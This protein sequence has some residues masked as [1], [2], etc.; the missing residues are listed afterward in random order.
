MIKDLS[1]IMKC[2]FP[3]DPSD[4]AVVGTHDRG[5]KCTQQ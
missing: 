3:F 5:I 4:R 2:M 1:L